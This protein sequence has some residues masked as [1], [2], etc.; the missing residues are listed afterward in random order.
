MQVQGSTF[1]GKIM[2]QNHTTKQVDATY[3]KYLIFTV[4]FTVIT[5]L[6]ALFTAFSGI[7][8]V[9]LEKAKTDE[10][11]QTTSAL[12]DMEELLGRQIEDLKSQLDKEKEASQVM[13]GNIASLKKQCAALK[14]ALSA[15]KA[16]A[17]P[18][19]P[20]PANQ[21]VPTPTPPAVGSPPEPV[22]APAASES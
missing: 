17:V 2:L 12:E 13:K 8:L 7:Q 19:Q 16:A 15:A 14:K 3:R 18:A 20:V 9:Q 5:L 22:A 6:A 21:T 4:V 1:R 11:S 10:I